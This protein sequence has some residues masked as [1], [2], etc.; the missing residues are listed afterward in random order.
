MTIPFIRYL[1]SK[2][3]ISQTVADQITEWARRNQNPIG[4]IAVAHGMIIGPQI[5]EVLDRQKESKKRFGEIAVE[6]G[7]LTEAKV[8]VLL[9]IQQQ[10][11]VTAITEALALS[12]SIPFTTGVRLLS[13]FVRTEPTGVFASPEP[14]VTT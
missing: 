10:R 12:G 9:Q 8:Q 3:Q 7:L 6:M 11:L 5:D 2:G 14:A 1:V 13:E 4:M